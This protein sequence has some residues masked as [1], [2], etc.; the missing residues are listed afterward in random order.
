MPRIKR[1]PKES[2][3]A[4][5][6]RNNAAWLAVQEF[7]KLRPTLSSFARM[8]TQDP[9][10]N[11]RLGQHGA[12][13]DGKNI[14]IAPPIELGENRQHEG[15]LCYTR[16]AEGEQNCLA[17]KA[18]ETTMWTLYHEVAHIVE[19]SFSP[20]TEE[21]RQI[22]RDLIREWHHDKCGHRPPLLSL[23]N[24][25]PDPLNL[26]VIDPY[27]PLLIKALEDARVDVRIPRAYDGLRIVHYTR[28]VSI[29]RTGIKQADGKYLKWTSAPEVGQVITGILVMA[30]GFDVEG[31]W[32]SPEVYPHL[33]DERVR[34]I[35]RRATLTENINDVFQLSVE[36]WRLLQDMGLVPV[37]KC[38]PPPPSL[39]NNKESDGDSKD[40]QPSG[41]ASDES[42]A[43]D[44]DGGCES[45]SGNR[46]DEESLPGDFGTDFE[47]EDSSTGGPDHEGGASDA[48]SDAPD[49]PGDDSDGVPGE[50]PGETTE[51][52]DPMQPGSNG[53]G[54]AG[55]GSES[56]RDNESAPLGE[57]STAD[58]TSGSEDSEEPGDGD[59]SGSAN[60]ID[61]SDDGS[62]QDD[63]SS[64][65][66]L[67]GEGDE[68]STQSG[69]GEA[70]DEL[71]DPRGAEVWEDASTQYAPERH[72]TEAEAATET[73]IIAILLGA[74]GGHDHD[75]AKDL[76]DPLEKGKTASTIEAEIQA[77]ARA[78]VQGIHF[79]TS[80]KELVGL[81]VVKFPAR[82]IKWTN[83]SHYRPD[84]FEPP[85]SLIGRVLLKARVAFSVNRRTKTAV[86]LRSGK[87][88]SR[89]LARRAPVGDDRVYMK[90]TR[91]GKRDYAV[92][93]GVDCSGSTNGGGRNER[94]KRAV[95][96]Q[97][98]LL[99]RLGVKFC[100]YAHTGG[101]NLNGS[102]S[103]GGSPETVWMLEI[104]TFDEPWNTETKSRLAKLPPVMNNFDG[105]SL[106]FY[107]K[108]ADTRRQTDKII[109]YY[110]D[111]AMPASNYEEERELLERE[112]ALCATKKYTLLAVGINTRSP[113]EFG[114][115]TVEV[116]CDEDLELV[117]KQLG[118]RLNQ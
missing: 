41:D 111:G 60:S 16:N 90:E 24:T 25:M 74:V 64:D 22:M 84:H 14:F 73:A 106:E 67:E 116:T 70:E 78:V 109:L 31:D 59:D 52:D 69:G 96:G 55:D 105:H 87:L 6:N 45:E 47:N 58:S 102:Y 33:A 103:Y 61:E 34:D 63:S 28:T 15:S 99:H 100:I 26:A 42:D 76:L 86:N 19:K 27:L 12:S 110:T 77:I 95:F 7:Q 51:S 39:P 81:E 113:E 79:D 93:I 71:P 37:N 35:A 89:S 48:A 8:M 50:T 43:S 29:F 49:V 57:E 2:K 30:L 85:E 56:D 80:S 11:V 92:V 54:E 10:V 75:P 101:Q 115:D 32:F 44:G 46:S 114:F 97:A 1:R 3:A 18:R 66:D 20:P 98:N 23:A 4:I 68:E 53:A 21:N 118:K 72:I 5:E 38:V 104:K 40:I 88:N 17:C 112:V 9:S 94:I 13:T 36:A 117:I 83:M 62:E 91:P 108:L 65:S 82:G 107:R